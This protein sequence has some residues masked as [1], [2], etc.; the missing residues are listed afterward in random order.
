MDCKQDEVITRMVT[1]THSHNHSCADCACESACQT[2][3]AETGQ[4]IHHATTNEACQH[5]F[6]R[7]SFEGQTA[8][9][10]IKFQAES[11]ELFSQ[12]PCL[13][14]N[15][16]LHRQYF[17]VDID[18]ILKIPDKPTPEKTCVFRL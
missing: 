6:K 16:F 7:G 4:H 2:C 1:T 3:Y 17:D 13:A 15:I 9:L 10:K 18:A 14:E 8:S 11:I 12:A 5:E